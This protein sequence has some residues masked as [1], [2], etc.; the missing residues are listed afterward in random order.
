MR[1]MFMLLLLSAAS[2]AAQQ[3]YLVKDLRTTGP[4]A[5]GSSPANMV[6]FGSSLYFST[7]GREESALWR[8]DA[9]RTL[10]LRVLKGSFTAVAPFGNR[11]IVG[12][13]SGGLALTDG[14]PGPVVRFT[15]ASVRTF[16]AAAN[17]LVFAGYDE[18]FSTDGTT[19]GT[20]RIDFHPQ[21]TWSASPTLL[22]A[23]G[24][25]VLFVS[26]VF[27][28]GITDGTLA[29]TTILST[30]IRAAGN[31]AVAGDHFF[32]IGGPYE[33][34][35][36]L[37]VSD[38]TI[39][40]THATRNTSSY[41]SFLYYDTSSPL[42]AI[43]GNRVIYWPPGDHGSSEWV[44]D[45]TDAGTMKVADV[46]TDNRP[47]AVLDGVAYFIGTDSSKN[48]NALWRTDGT[49]AGTRRVATLPDPYSGGIS[50]ALGSI[51][52]STY[53]SNGLVHF[54]ILN[55]DSIRVLAQT[56]VTFPV[57]EFN[58]RIYFSGDDSEHGREL[59]SSDGTPEGTSMAADLEPNV[60]PSSY[61]S[62]LGASAT[63]VLFYAVDNSTYGRWSS[64]GTADGTQ[65]FPFHIDG[66]LRVGDLLY[67]TP[68]DSPKVL[69]RSD[70]TAEGTTQV[71]TL[72][73]PMSPVIAA[74]N[75]I[76]LATGGE[77]WATD[78]T[79]EGTTRIG[80]ASL[81]NV[82]TV[83]GRVLF[84]GPG[85]LFELN[86]RQ[87]PRLLIAGI[88]SFFQAAGKLYFFTPGASSSSISVT[89][90]TA[91]GV[92]VLATFP[93]GQGGRGLGSIEDR[94]VFTVNDG[95]HGYELWVTDGTPEGT[96]LVRDILPGPRNGIVYTRTAV[97]KDR[98][99][100]TADDGTFGPHVWSTDGTPEGTIMLPPVASSL[101]ATVAKGL[102][103]FSG[104][105]DLHGS[106]LWQSDGTV[107]GTRLVA[108]IYPGV[109]S[110]APAFMT[111]T[112][113]T[114]FFQATT[115]ENGAELWALPL[116]GRTIAI[117][118]ARAAS[119]SAIA[120]M[121]VSLDGPST[122]PVSARWSSTTGASGR[123]A[124][125]PGDRTKTITFPITVDT[126]T[127]RNR[128]DYVRL[129]DVRGATP[130]KTL[131]TLIEE[132]AAPTADLALS[133]GP[134]PDVSKFS[135]V[136][137]NR[138][139]NTAPGS[140]VAERNSYNGHASVYT[141]TV[142]SIAPGATASIAFGAGGYLD[143][144]VTSATADPD[145]SNN[146]LTVVASTNFNAGLMIAIAPAAPSAGGHATLLVGAK[147]PVTLMSS[148]P[149]V[150]AVPAT[151]SSGTI[152]LVALAPGRT[153][154]TASVGTAKTSV[155]VGVA[156]A[157]APLRWP[158]QMTFTIDPGDRTFG[159]RQHLVAKFTGWAWDANVAPSG[160]VTFLQ[161]GKPLAV[162]FVN[163]GAVAETSV[164]SLP[165]GS[166]AISASYAGDAHF[167]GETA[168]PQT[169]TIIKPPPVA[170]YGSVAPLT[171][172]TAEMTI[173]VV[174]VR[175]RP[176]TG[177]LTLT[178]G[179]QLLAANVPLVGGIARVTT[180]RLPFVTVSY[181]G[182]DLYEPAVASITLASVHRRAAP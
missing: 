155:D 45:G 121:T 91:D 69:Y 146:T 100:F 169:V 126:T 111:L 143:A 9:G 22:G 173:V 33:Q 165:V 125:A 14:T 117:D 122:E 20:L 85:A 114:L 60:A 140:A 106:E 28:L 137:T 78:G 16:V 171:D 108:D 178:N 83:G 42:A 177:T 87:P 59:W 135:L 149:S 113:D 82:T 102:A 109:E 141:H 145:P 6:T 127:R 158:A 34:H 162:A 167:F 131:G 62:P 19:D 119:G 110:S 18:L 112:R 105:D 70:G 180:K 144:T 93:G 128:F 74:G 29:G 151:A 12:P 27:G 63:H 57:A 61:P 76:Y 148:D 124:F 174:A 68:S 175:S 154:I 90:G 8:L 97:L 120:T 35:G 46:Y 73:F 40:G 72:P 79:A 51:W 53:G 150:I 56:N 86:G 92:Q 25:R 157:G 67:F 50:S 153:T 75:L 101:Q 166:Y 104:D 84:T 15:D 159:S 147:S 130:V 71:C 168:A 41:P 7:N 179:S 43:S 163:R 142:P 134:G 5:G 24:G 47:A 13:G 115:L 10:P 96:K 129:A 17:R 170:F 31:I 161:D 94:F 99:L 30:S 58:G 55:G 182:D 132:G 38:G 64:D 133:I 21:S 156:A 26:S 89:D 181:S 52:I 3:P 81:S 32:F 139:P 23:F 66:N 118:D 37:W 11:L 1:R 39:A 48:P 176:A 123:I 152:D 36:A 65:V 54:G 95:V 49:A 2:A 77:V 138:G 80:T 4:I 44:S 88:S 103:Y 116:P 172:T 98:I 160:P 136:V 107:E 164:D